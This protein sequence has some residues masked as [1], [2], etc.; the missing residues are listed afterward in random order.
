MRWFFNFLLFL[1]FSLS[2][3]NASAFAPGNNKQ[4]FRDTRKTDALHTAS[5]VSD[6]PE[7]KISHIQT[8][9][10]GSD[11]SSYDDNTSEEEDEDHENSKDGKKSIADAAYFTSFLDADNSLDPGATITRS[12][13]SCGHFH[14]GSSPRYIL[15]CVYRI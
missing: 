10:A 8:Y 14:I 6:L 4:L 12:R 9:V 1:L 3:V 7:S 5:R 11:E 13:A 15:Y 2:G